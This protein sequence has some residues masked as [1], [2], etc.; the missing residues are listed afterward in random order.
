M[1][2]LMAPRL[3][4]ILAAA[5]AMLAAACSSSLQLSP[6]NL[7]EGS[8][9]PYYHGGASA[10]GCAPA[11][12]FA[13]RLDVIWETSM[14]GKPAGPLT[15]H[16][17]SLAVPSTRNR[18]EMYETGTG[19]RSGKIKTKGPVQSGLVAE[20]GYGYCAVSIGNRLSCFDLR[21]GDEQWKRF[22]K[23]TAR[24]A[25]VAAN[26]LVIG[27]ATG[28]LTAY[29][30]ADGRE[31]WTF[32]ETQDRFMAPPAA[33]HGLV[34]QPGVSG[35]LYALDPNDGTERYRVKVDGPM[36]GGVA[37]AE[38]VVGADMPGR[39]Y[40]IDA[41]DGTVRWRTDIG[42]PVWTKPAVA[43]GRVF[44]GHSGGELVALNLVDG[45]VLWRF[46]AFEVIAASAAVIGRFVAV[47]TLGGN[48]Y[49][50]DAASGSV[51][52]R[53]KLEGRIDQAPATDGDRL[54]LATD[55]GR[56]ICLGTLPGVAAEQAEAQA[57]DGTESPEAG[58]SGAYRDNP[59]LT[60]PAGWTAAGGKAGRAGGGPPGSK[61]VKR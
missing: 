1:E 15:L 24:G 59:G 52:S 37:V 19:R 47:G 3:L 23:E 4:T 56:V 50:L 58:A 48:V 39:V 13:G 61:A 25:I 53:R 10:T 17:G 60:P 35:F 46:Q 29:D 51:L 16:G 22:V 34:F 27:S 55:R 49:V 8:P 21:S 11:G 26:R 18:V 36:V 31:V 38:L 7:Q 43:E 44:V 9:W 54:Y 2:F 5:A 42:A 28:R 33:G 40:G 30:P 32:E 45:R 57:D 14:A 12:E 20:G 6:E 41:Q